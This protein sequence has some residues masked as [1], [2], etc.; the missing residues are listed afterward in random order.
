MGFGRMNRS[1]LVD[2]KMLREP[3]QRT[4]CKGMVRASRSSVLLKIPTG[5]E[6]S[7]VAG[8]EARSQ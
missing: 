4:A 3:Q 7:E 5:V 8:E 2:K 6:V 1:L